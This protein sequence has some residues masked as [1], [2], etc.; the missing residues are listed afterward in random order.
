VLLGH[1]DRRPRP[2]AASLYRRA[3]IEQRAHEL[4][5]TAVERRHPWAAQLGTQP[6]EPA[7]HAHWMRQVAT[8]AAYR[9]R[10]NIHDRTILGPPSA[11]IEH[12]E[13]RR[14][15]QQAVTCALALHHG[16]TDT[17]PAPTRSLDLQLERSVEL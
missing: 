12:T 6:D 16:Q 9:D 10:W 2:R 1:R 4:A 11:S 15:A 13:Q 14:I 5:T 8:I 17:A 7:A 3:L